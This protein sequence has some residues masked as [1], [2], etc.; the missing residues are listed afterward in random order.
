MAGRQTV[1][2]QCR[3]NNMNRN[4][5]ETGSYSARNFWSAARGNYIISGGSEEKR[6]MVLCDELCHEMSSGNLPTI[7]LTT[8]DGAEREM[9]SR[10]RR[11]EAGGSLYVTSRNYRNYLFFNGWGSSEISRF[12][13]KA[14]AMMGYEA[15]NLPIYIQ[16]FTHI[17]SRYY[18]PGLASMMALATYDDDQIARI[19]EEAGAT[20]MEVAHIR[21]YSEEGHL[22]RHMLTQLETVFSPLATE[23][24]GYNL[25]T[26]SLKPGETYLINIRSHYQALINFYFSEELRLAL[27][28]SGTAHIVFADLPFLEGDGLR[29]LITEQKLR[30][31]EIGISVQNAAVLPGDSI[32]N[33][34]SMLLLLDGGMADGDLYKLLEPL[35]TYTHF[36]PVLS[37]QPT[38][39]PRATFRRGRTWSVQTEPNRLRV[40]PADTRGFAAVLYGMRGSEILL[41]RNLR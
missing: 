32:D 26:G 25:A 23:G 22:F 8:S 19:G 24:S 28:R 1:E 5:T 14:A 13:T 36:E 6:S 10:M 39:F 35:G 12:L 2:A 16:S 31:A 4:V 27:D 33:F 34:N 18:T 30:G 21:N 40:R 37:V 9:I 20:S 11:G 38:L 41:V 15:R 29:E 17:L 3:R 7:V